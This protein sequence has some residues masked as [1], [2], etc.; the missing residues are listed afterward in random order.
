[1]IGQLDCKEEGTEGAVRAEY[2][3]I[4]NTDGHKE[5]D[6]AKGGKSEQ[7]PENKDYMSINVFASFVHSL[8][9]LF[10]MVGVLIAAIIIKLRVQ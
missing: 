4:I 9:D 10:V 2:Q 5:E 1:M 3:S 7:D 6:E 8:S